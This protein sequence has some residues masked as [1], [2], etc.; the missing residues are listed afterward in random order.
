MAR[1]GI[2]V[3]DTGWGPGP[4]WTGA[5]NLSSNGIRSPDRPVSSYTKQTSETKIRKS[6]SQESSCPA[7]DF[8]YYFFNFPSFPLLFVS[9]S[10]LCIQNVEILKTRR[11]TEAITSVFDSARSNPTP[12]FL[13]TPR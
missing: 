8:Q 11:K 5:E 1:R 9:P 12:F 2:Q 4:V 7:Q 6:Y 10:S 3:E 13:Q